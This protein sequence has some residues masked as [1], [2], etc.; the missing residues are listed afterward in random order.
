LACIRLER[1]LKIL[2]EIW[3]QRADLSNEAIESLVRA[4]IS[5]HDGASARCSVSNRLDQPSAS[6]PFTPPSTTPS[7]S[8]VISHPAARCASSAKTLS[9][10]GELLPQPEPELGL[11]SSP[12]P[13]LVRVTTPGRRF[14]IGDIAS[15]G[16]Y[17]HHWNISAP[18]G[19]VETRPYLD[20]RV[21]AL[22]LSLP[23]D[24][25]YP[26]R[27]F[28]PVL[29]AALADAVRSSIINRNYKPNFS[30]RRSGYSRHQAWLERLVGEAPIDDTI[31]DRTVL[32]DSVNKAAMGLF[33][34][35]QSLGRLRMT[36]TYLMW[37]SRRNSRGASR[38][39]VV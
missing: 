13:N 23:L 3:R 34:D 7:T 11:P 8:S 15:I 10:R 36:L 29:A 27:P 31:I 5:R 25:S 30:R 38:R 37:L 22:A 6:C 28:K 39:Q 2:R 32:L 16:G 4:G 18:R 21:I 24:S 35:A 12:G 33:H 26:P 20:A 17:W 19:I 14:G 9:K 1:T